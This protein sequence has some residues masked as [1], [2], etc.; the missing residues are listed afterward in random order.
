MMSFRSFTQKAVQ[1]V[2]H[3]ALRAL[4]FA[5][6]H[7]SSA[8]PGWFSKGDP[9]VAGVEVDEWN[10]MT[11]SA[12]WACVRLIAETVGSLPFYLYRHLPDGGKE[13]ARDHP[14]WRVLV[15]QPNPEMSPMTFHETLEAHVLLWGNSYAQIQRDG[16]GRPV[17]L[18]PFAP[19]RV[20]PMRDENGVLYYHYTPSAGGQPKDYLAQDVWHV[21]GLGFDGIMGYSVI[22]M[23]RQSLSLGL[24]SEKY[25]ASFFGNGAMPKGALKH[26]GELSEP[27]RINL[28]R[29][30][31][32]T[33]QGTGNANRIAILE[34]GLD[35]QQIGIS[36]ED[37]QFLETRQFQVAEVCRWFNVPPHMIRDL[38]RSTNN[39]IE[40]QSIDYGTYTIR[41]RLVR[42][43]QE[44]KRKL[45]LESDQRAFFPKY[46]MDEL[47]R[48]D[49]ASRYAAYNIGRL[50]G[51]LNSDEIRA[52]ENMNPI[53]D[54]K[55]KEYLVPS[56][57]ALTNGG[58]NV[59]GATGTGAEVPPKDGGAAQK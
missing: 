10:A 24:A 15:D 28:R 44:T 58:K 38:S 6:F 43:E 19:N 37:A 11:Y 7:P 26:P 49:M 20:K 13:L 59:N 47:L 53:P 17:A 16:G 2:G 30:W 54:G 41:P 8:V 57:M 22:S 40:Q 27:A 9:P 32:D 42:R 5:G 21:P 34:E 4:K 23:A 18:W 33:H 14:L 35:F 50:G 52:K 29:T 12:V 46:D 55:G 3:V 51:W 36:P 31:E 25:G 48:G 39:N 56:N 1:T 45:L